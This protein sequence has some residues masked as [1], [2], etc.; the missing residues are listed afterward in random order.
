MDYY[1]YCDIIR[2]TLINGNVIYLFFCRSLSPGGIVCPRICGRSK[3]HTPPVL[4][5]TIKSKQAVVVRVAGWIIGWWKGSKSEQVLLG[6]HKQCVKL[7]EECYYRWVGCGRLCVS[8]IIEIGRFIPFYSTFPW[9]MWWYI[10]YDW[11]CTGTSCC[12]STGKS[13][14]IYRTNIKSIQLNTVYVAQTC[15]I[16]KDAMDR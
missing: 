15:S 12:Y 6:A 10:M 16:R 7:T 11:S 13:T 1:Y 5:C 14:Y 3:C 2:C 8:C 4:L 9:F